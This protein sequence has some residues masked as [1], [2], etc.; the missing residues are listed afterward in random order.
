[1][2]PGGG[3]SVCIETRRHAR[4][5]VSSVS[6]L[7][8]GPNRVRKEFGTVLSITARLAYDRSHCA[9]PLRSCPLR[10]FA[11]SA[12]MNRAKIEVAA[13]QRSSSTLSSRRSSTKVRIG[14]FEIWLESPSYR[15]LK[16]N[17]VSAFRIGSDWRFNIETLDGWRAQMELKA[18]VFPKERN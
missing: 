11:C 8:S 9:E 17:Q 18:H 4:R 10:R 14:D 6:L 1:M 13:L 15:L 5:H 3:R 12:G 7:L 16:R 2:L